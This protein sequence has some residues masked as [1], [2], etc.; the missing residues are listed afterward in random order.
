MSARKPE[1]RGALRHSITT[2]TIQRLVLTLLAVFAAVSY[3]AYLH[4]VGI[5]EAQAQEQL[6]KYITE[7]SKRESQVFQLALDNHQRIREEVLERLAI[8]DPDAL[9]RFWS[10]FE[11]YPDE[12]I[13]NRR[14]GFD[15]TRQAGLF[16]DYG[17]EVDAALAHRLNVYQQVCTL[18]G[19]AFLSRFEKTYISTPDNTVAMFWPKQPEWVM[20][21]GRDLWMPGEEN[22]WAAD[23]LHNPERRQLWSGLFYD[24]VAGRW[25]ISAE[26]PIYLNDQHIGTINH[27]LYLNTLIERTTRDRLQGTYNL[28]VRDDGR[29]I[30]HPDYVEELK[31]YEGRYQIA[32][33]DDDHLKSIH[34]LLRG[35]GPERSILFNEPYNEYLAVGRMEGTDWFFVTVYPRALIE[36]RSFATARLIM[37]LGVVALLLLVGVLIFLVRCGITNPLHHFVGVTHR[38]ASGVYE[39]FEESDARGLLRRKDE[40]GLLARALHRMVEVIRT[41]QERLERLNQT[42]EDRVA[43]RTGELSRSNEKLELSLEGGRLGSFDWDMVEDRNVIDERW[44]A[45]LGYRV[46]QIESNYQGWRALVH[47]H[48]VAAARDALERYLGGEGPHFEA[49]YRMRA[50]TGG[51]LWILARGKIVARDEQGKPLRLAGTHMDITPIKQTEQ[52]L[53][54]ATREAERALSELRTTQTQLIHSEKMA[55]LGQLIAGIAHE[56]NTPLGAIKSSGG[57]IV[58]SLDQSLRNL[59]RVH[60]LLGAEEER[61]FFRLL[62]ES[63]E[64]TELLTSREARKYTRALAAELEGEGVERSRQTADLLVQLKVLKEPTRYLPLIRH[65]EASFILDTAY[66]VASIITNTT[67]INNAVERAAKIIYALKS[68]SRQDPSGDPVEASLRD[69]LETVLTLYHN[70]IKQGTELLRHYDEIPPLRCHPDEL[71]QVWTNLIHNALQAMEYRGTLTVDLAREGEEAVVSIT[72]TGPGIPAE[73]R[74]RIFEPF[75]TTK[76]SGEGSGLGLDI[77]KKIIDK[78]RGRIEFESEPGLGTT[79]RVHLPYG[80]V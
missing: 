62:D 14:E 5:I 70:Q 63:R 66:G 29:L 58:H 46:D 10:R 55:A 6:G 78:H 43:R 18:Y 51:Y 42:L 38:V 2:K 79:F 4:V 1:A 76:P 27:D 48:D 59:P 71:G 22:V 39:V 15:G 17:I 32:E 67:N 56:V 28:I 12:V 72:D 19:R 47:P 37:G 13:R 3:L 36:E 77:V 44:A 23:A 57:N 26:T 41:S 52:R 73:V 30:F 20:E 31:S 80:E 74:E 9:D 64:H 11:R 24:D 45:M 53:A 61:L 8:H 25:M 16:V 35:A 69:G 34:A 50:A 68:Y 40:I 65:P 49:Q 75:F 60:G 54:E 7:R 21:A 33:S